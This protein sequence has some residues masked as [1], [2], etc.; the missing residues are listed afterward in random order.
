MLNSSA[1][2]TVFA[3]SC[4]AQYSGMH[5]LQTDEHV[6]Q[7]MA[8]MTCP[9]TRKA[10]QIA[11]IARLFDRI[12]AIALA[13]GLLCLRPAAIMGQNL[14]ISHLPHYRPGEVAFTGDF[15]VDPVDRKGA[16][17]RDER[18]CLVLS[19]GLIS[20]SF[21][22]GPDGA[23]TGLHHLRTSESFVRSIRPE[24]MLTL[25]GLNIPVGGLSGQDVHNFFSPEWLPGLQRIAG[26][27]HL[28]AL[29]SHQIRE[30]FPWKKRLEW[31][32]GDLPWPPDG[33]ELVMT[34]RLQPGD[35]DALASNT[36]NVV[37]DY[38][39]GVSVEVHYEMYDGLPLLCKWI[40][41]DNQSA[42]ELTINHF[43]SEILAFAEPESSV[44]D[45][46]SWRK[47]NITVETDFAFGNLM[48]PESALGN[49]YTWEKDTVY[50]TIVNYNR[51]QPSLLLCRPE[52]GPEATVGPGERFSSYRIWELLHDSH[53]RERRGLSQRKM[54]RTI[55]PWVTENPILMHVRQADDASVRLAI[56]QC[57][58]VG[59]EMVIMTFGSGFNLED[60][61]PENYRRMRSLAGYAHER[62]VALGGYSLLASRS[63]GPDDDVVMPEGKTPTFGRSP[64]LQSAWGN[65]YFEKLYR[66]YRETGLDLLEHDGSYPG[67]PCW[68]ASHPGHRGYGDSQWRQFERIRDFYQWCR[69]EGIYLNVPDWY[70]LN[71]STKTA[72]GYRETNWSLPRAWQE[73]IERQNIYDGTWEKTPSMGWMFVPLVE[74]HGGGAEATIEPLRD[75]LDHYGQ[76]L[77]NLFGAGVQA[78]YRGPRLYDADETRALVKKWVDFYKSHR[79]ILDADIVH[80][81]RPDGQDYDGWLHV[82]PAGEEKGLMVLYNPLGSDIR[83]TIE[84]GLYYTGLKERAE[85]SHEGGAP[86]TVRI[87]A[88]NTLRLPVHIPARGVTWYVFK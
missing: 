25:D 57:A 1:L 70:F 20:R 33:I 22:V 39:T 53:D 11:L 4:L 77:A 9:R 10:T 7:R 5:I 2:R 34:Y 21:S 55:A 72:M 37:P 75:H 73:I 80:L 78:C 54:Y 43:T 59:F 71:G 48:N 79:Q 29:N 26:R 44:G 69:S 68:S 40:E 67:D 14:D 62:G 41:I 46:R 56:D 8:K 65:E 49:S 13:F 85:M 64:C 24:A 50:K 30:R 60:I 86:V 83:K 45:L 47:P 88:D 12:P 3:T 27:F 15:L 76:R 23:T 17:Y 42:K 61:S 28:V 52:I 36:G 87:G 38:L 51:I 63:I 18:G 66:F 81:R 35:I 74:Y 16:L 32:P 6:P 84:V 58:D 31:M 19:N 82:N